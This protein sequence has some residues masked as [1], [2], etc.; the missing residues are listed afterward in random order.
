MTEEAKEHAAVPY[1]QYFCILGFFNPC[2]LPST[3][4]F[5]I[6]SDML[7]FGSLPSQCMW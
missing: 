2:A 3:N 4:S 7:Q 6:S 5:F 1:A